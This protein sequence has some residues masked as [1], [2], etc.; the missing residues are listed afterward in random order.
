M[1]RPASVTS[2]PARRAAAR[3]YAKELRAAGLRKDL[4]LATARAA[5]GPGTVV[6][7]KEQPSRLQVGPARGDVRRP[8]GLIVPRV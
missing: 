1:A 5:F 7:A 6:A 3:A 8:S 4:A 2:R